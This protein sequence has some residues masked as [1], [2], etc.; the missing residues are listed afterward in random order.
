MKAI[1]GKIQYIIFGYALWNLYGLY[2]EHTE[3]KRLTEADIPGIERNISKKRKEIRELR[4]FLKDLEKEKEKMRIV[5]EEIKK[6][7][8]RLPT[9]IS[10]PEN[11]ETLRRIGQKLNIQDMDIKQLPEENKGFYFAKKYQFTGKGTFLQF[12]I[13]FE[14]LGSLNQIFNVRDVVLDRLKKNQRGRFQMINGNIKIESYRYNAA[15]EIE[16]SKKERGEG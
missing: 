12:L 15:S 10:D 6:L 9:K 14:K 5:Q 16:A 7:Q 4:K 13:F 3:Q 11:M 2:S 1:F 8:E